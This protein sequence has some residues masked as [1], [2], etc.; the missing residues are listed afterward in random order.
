MKLDYRGNRCRIPHHSAFVDPAL[1]SDVG[2]RF[3]LEVS[4]LFVRT[5]ILA[6]RALDI[7][8]MSVVAF[9]QIAVVAIH[10]TN[11]IR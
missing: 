6:Q 7:D 8:W 9:D 3:E 11:E 1:C 4:L 5:V 2:L 10:R